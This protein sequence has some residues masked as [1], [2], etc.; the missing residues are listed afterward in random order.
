MHP[1][2]RCK[3]IIPLLSSEISEL[4]NELIR[5]QASLQN[6]KALIISARLNSNAQDSY[7]I[8]SPKAFKET[9]LFYQDYNIIF[10]EKD[11]INNLIHY[12]PESMSFLLD[13]NW[14]TSLHAFKHNTKH[15]DKI[16]FKVDREFL[17][18]SFQINETMIS[19]FRE[20]TWAT[21]V[22]WRL[23]RTYEKRFVKRRKEI[24]DPLQEQVEKLLPKSI[25]IQQNIETIRCIAFPSVLEG[26]VKGIKD[27]Y[28]QNLTTLTSGFHRKD[29]DVRHIVLDYQHRMHPEISTFPRE[30]FYSEKDDFGKNIRALLD[31][32]GMKEKRV[33]NYSGYKN[34]R[35]WIHVRGRVVRNSNRGEIE[36]LLQEIRQFIDWAK[37]EIPPENQGN[38]EIAVLT[39]YRRQERELRNRLREYCNQPRSESRFRKENCQI[40]LHTVDKF[41][42][43]EADIVFLS[44]VQN[45]RDGFMDS[46]NRLNVAITR[47]RYQFVILGDYDYFS[48]NGQSKTR[49]E[50]LAELAKNTIRIN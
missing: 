50:D 47:A 37:R 28:V 45:Q 15:R 1:L 6:T 27:R 33:W 49:S 24:K 44:M 30:R 17:N 7:Q 31:G 43:Q 42:G 11:Y 12:L 10:I 29:L 22:G 3:F 23:N 20:K 13:D 36:R 18:D 41:Q 8:I 21:E 2:N 48:Q 35:I 38:W 14:N 19:F 5:R 46:P 4:N 32:K 40:K 39:F 26:L 34:R 9:A 25:N 16:S